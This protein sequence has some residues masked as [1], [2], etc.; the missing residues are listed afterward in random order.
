MFEHYPVDPENP[1]KLLDFAILPDKIGTSEEWWVLQAMRRYDPRIRAQDIEMRMELENRPKW[2]AIQTRA[3]R[4]WGQKFTM[5]SWH[6]KGKWRRGQPNASREAVLAMLTPAQ[7]TANSTRG[8]TP[9]LID[10]ALGEAGG[11]IPWPVT[12]EGEGEGRL[13]RNRMRQNRL[14][15]LQQ[16][17]NRSDPG[18]SNNPAGFNSFFLGNHF[19]A[20]N[21]APPASDT[22]SNE[23]H[24]EDNDNATRNEESVDNNE[25]TVDDEPANNES[26]EDNES[27]DDDESADN[28]NSADN[29]GAIDDDEAA[30]NDSMDIEPKDGDSADRYMS[31]LDDTEA[32]IRSQN[33]NGDLVD[34]E[35][36]SSYDIET[37]IKREVCTIRLGAV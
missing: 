6:T 14:T 37:D 17:L 21:R 1:R 28:D 20:I 3:T 33:T 2:N 12:K 22:L 19:Q 26:T 8:S 27:V 36:H 34:R 15:A 5:L 13:Q 7:V 4:N 32:D 9:G 30:D 10:P 25:S 23:S 24:I 11:R 18:P 31:D 16:V 35:L 29:D